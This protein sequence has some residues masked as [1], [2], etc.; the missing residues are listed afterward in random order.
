MSL[1]P[2]LGQARRDRLI[3]AGFLGGLALV[4]SGTVQERDPYWQARAG[5]EL[6]SG[7]PL[8]HPDTWSWAPVSGPFRQTSPAWNVVLGLAWHFVGFAGI[9]LVTLVSIGSYLAV[10]L[11]LSRR[12]RARALPGMAGLLLCIFAALA[13][14]SPRAA[15]VAE[16]LFLAS[17]LAADRWAAWSVGRGVVRPA[18]GALLGSFVI[19][20]A[21]NWIHLS[22]FL[23][24]A[25]AMLASA[26]VWWLREGLSRASRAALTAASTIGFAGGALLGP[27]GLGAWADSERVQRA[28]A[29]IVKEWMSPWTPGL[30]ARWVV[31]CVLAVGIGA[32][33]VLW[34]LLTRRGSD[35][36]DRLPVVAALAVVGVPA[37][38]GGVFVIRFIGIALLCMAPLAA[39]SVTVAVDRIRLRARGARSGVLAHPR[40]R[41]WLTGEP[42]RVALPVVLVLLLPGLA[43]GVWPLA[44]PLPEARLAWALPVGCHLFSEGSTAGAVLLLR[45]DVKVWV[46]GRADYYGPDRNI[47]AEYLLAH[48]RP[49]RLVPNGTTCVM[50]TDPFSKGLRL[51]LDASP[52]WR[53]AASSG[54][55]AVW[56]PAP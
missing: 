45:P 17:V 44:R 37:A 30:Q 23:L 27:Y 8:A 54:A 56:V 21:G 39:V 16:T 34:L 55:A 18:A 28:C 31:P 53:R 41:H 33:W 36:D 26:A 9:F 11:A 47:E 20:L 10:V 12:L 48:D 35:G 13:M 29:G 32:V 25:A 2:R 14:L 19:G 42:W 6:L 46:D 50:L 52:A 7:S 38:L 22:W 15:L 3:V 1:G 24:T 51:A 43:L 40:I 49:D 5:L 4:R